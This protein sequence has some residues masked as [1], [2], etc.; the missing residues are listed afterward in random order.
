MN[1]TKEEIMQA[2]KKLMIIFL[3]VAW[4]LFLI[5]IPL[6]GGLVGGALNLVV[7]ILSIITITRGRT[8]LGVTMLVLSIVVSPII[9]IIGSLILSACAVHAVATS[10]EFQ[11]SVQE[12]QHSAREL[13]HSVQQLNK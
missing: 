8:G 13:H 2:P 7:F 5:P 11:H 6:I 1:E 10:P 3:I 4:I 12:L 9:Y